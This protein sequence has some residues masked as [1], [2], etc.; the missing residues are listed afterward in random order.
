MVEREADQLDGVAER[1]GRAD[2][3]EQDRALLH[4]PQGVERRAREEHREDDEVHH[5]GEVLELADHR[6]QQEAQ[7][8]QHQP[9]QQQGGEHGEVAQGR[10]P[11][12]P[13]PG[14]RQEDIGL[15]AGDQD[16]RHQLAGEQPPARHRA[17]QQHPHRAHLAVVDH[18]QRALHAAE[19]QD[20]P[21]QA[22]RDVDLVEDVGDVGRLVGDAQHRAEAGGEDEQPDQRPDQGGEEPPALVQEAQ[23]LAPQDAL[24]AQEPGIAASRRGL[25]APAPAAAASSG[26][27]SS[28]RRRKSSTSRGWRRSARPS[29]TSRRPMGRPGAA[30]RNSSR[31]ASMIASCREWVTNR[32]VAPCRSSRSSSRRRR[33]WAVGSSRETKGS[34]SSRR[35]GSTTK[36]RAS[37]ARRAMPRDSREAKTPAA[38]SRPTSASAAAILG[39]GSGRLG[40]DQAQIVLDRA[41][42]QQARLLEHVGQPGGRREL[43]AA[44][45]AL[46]Q[47]GH[48]VEQGG[49]AAARGADDRQ[50]HAAARPRAVCRRARA[51]PAPARPPGSG[52]PQ[53]EAQRRHWVARRSSGCS[54]PH[55][56]S[57]TTT[58]KES[59]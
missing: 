45:E 28:S 27:S 10:R 4:P 47:A 14:D 16:R 51:W 50:A 5:A 25:R 32:A 34:S 12:V 59:A 7:G 39:A 56:I 31:S 21:A 24:E 9:R 37:A 22:G 33:R 53:V 11:D 30:D 52:A 46:D 43:E 15:E 6:R 55:S 26:F 18:R 20:H 36:A 42:G 2:P 3:V 41:P 29:A 13:E 49:L 58:M 38:P 17:H 1:V 19:Q 48:D 40:Q 23:E 35:P 44:G 8:A 54:T 57:C